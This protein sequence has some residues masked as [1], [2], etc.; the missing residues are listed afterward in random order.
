MASVG[1]AAG[2]AAAFNAPIAA[3]TFTLEEVVGDL[4]QTVLSGIIV[5]AAI[6]SVVERS[7]LG[8]HP[9][10]DLH[11]PYEMGPATTLI[12]YALLGVCA[13]LIS[14]LFTD[15]LLALRAHNRK[16]LEGKA[17]SGLGN[18][19]E[20][21]VLYLLALG[22]HTHSISS[23]SYDAWASTYEWRTV[24]DISFLYAG[25]LFTH[26]LSHLWIDFRGIQ[27]AFMRDR[28]IDYFE[29]SRRATYV[30]REYARRNPRQWASYT[31]DCWGLTA[32]DG[33]GPAR[34]SWR[35]TPRT[36]AGSR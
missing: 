34:G 5:A 8:Q 30:H 17:P 4:D 2:I 35:G 19:L 22:S 3:V 11:R 26:Q 14:L 31:A 18:G 24:Y 29:N 33:P 21:L 27:D 6:A 13:G 20:A 9:A 12:S 36:C 7:I 23:A 15:S 16:T 10:F 25:P 28:G 32:S 1:V